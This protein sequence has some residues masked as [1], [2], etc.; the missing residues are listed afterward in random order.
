M[1]SLATALP[2]EI[3]RVIELRR[4]YESLR[5]TPGVNVE[6]AVAMMSAAIS[7]ALKSTGSGDVVEMLRAY[8]EL[9]GFER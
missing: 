3:E 2:A 5:G 6:P 9:K 1:A 4:Q 8:E 7:R